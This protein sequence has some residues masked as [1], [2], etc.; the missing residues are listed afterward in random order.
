MRVDI[1]LEGV[2]GKHVVV[3]EAAL[4]ALQSECGMHREQAIFV[5]LERDGRQSGA[6]AS[7]QAL[8]EPDGLLDLAVGQGADMIRAKVAE[9]NDAGEREEEAYPYDATQPSSPRSRL[10]RPG[11]LA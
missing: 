6:G 11:P 10:H 4:Y 5:E 2:V 9:I 8:G 1:E 7:G 3:P